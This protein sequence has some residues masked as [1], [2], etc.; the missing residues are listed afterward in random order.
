MEF[1]LTLVSLMFLINF[2][3]F[4]VFAD[5]RPF[6]RSLDEAVGDT[7]MG[8]MGSSYATEFFARCVDRRGYKTM[9]EIMD[10]FE[11]TR[12]CMGPVL[13]T[14]DSASFF[15]AILL[16]IKTAN[17]EE[18]CRKNVH[19]IEKCIAAPIDSL[20]ACTDS[21]GHSD[22]EVVKSAISGAIRYACYN[23]GDRIKSFVK[24]EGFKCLI[25]LDGDIIEDCL[26][27]RSSLFAQMGKNISIFTEENCRIHA[28]SNKCVIDSYSA[29]MKK[30]SLKSIDFVKGII[31]AAIEDTPCPIGN[32]THFSVNSSGVS[33][34]AP[35]SYILSLLLLIFHVS[36]I[37]SI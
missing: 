13:Y 22:L 7:I 33:S 11:K 37:R 27:K 2:S 10:T 20:K 3:I 26:N 16:L 35:T 32:G 23:D 9:K 30:S 36:I 34:A 6:G 1:V 8:E 29:C 31:T 4:P 18:I 21:V 14:Q 28:T 15:E 19:V 24:E 25:D 12:K 17:N 5:D